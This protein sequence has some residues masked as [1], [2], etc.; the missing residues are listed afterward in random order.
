VQ[1]SPRQLLAGS[2]GG[3]PQI[4]QRQLHDADSP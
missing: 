1:D 4:L 2:L 3:L